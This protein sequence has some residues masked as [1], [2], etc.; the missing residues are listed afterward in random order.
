MRLSL[1]SPRYESTMELNVRKVVSDI[2]KLPF[3][4]D[5][6]NTLQAYYLGGRCTTGSNGCSNRDVDDVTGEQTL[7]PA[8]KSSRLA[9]Y[10]RTMV[11]LQP[12]FRISVP[13]T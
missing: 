9:S 13:L 2:S 3:D 5:E 7:C 12:L 4:A 8:C 10:C 11:S 6:F 1:K